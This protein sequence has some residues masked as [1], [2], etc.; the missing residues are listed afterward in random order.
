M[1][2]HVGSFLILVPITEYVSDNDVKK[3][4]TVK[5]ISFYIKNTQH[6]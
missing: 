5:L 1:V 3:V 6:K 4:E 2:K